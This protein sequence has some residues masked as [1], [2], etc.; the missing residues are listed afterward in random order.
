MYRKR[1]ITIITVCFFLIM[2]CSICKASAQ[3][4]LPATDQGALDMELSVLD[5]KRA[6]VMTGTPQDQIVN[7]SVNNAV[8]EYYNNYTD[9]CIALKQGKIDC[10]VNNTIQF[11][12]IG[13]EYPEFSYVNR[14]MTS[15]D[16]GAVFPLTNHGS[17][18][19]NEFDSYLAEIEKDGTLD[20]LK[21][22][23]L[24]PNDWEPCEIPSKG[25]KGTLKLGTSTSMKPFS[26]IVNEK[27]SGFD[28]AVVSEFCRRQG[29]GLQIEDCDLAGVL[30]GI[31]TG[32]YDIGAGQIAWTQER[33][34]SVLY[35]DL[36]VSQ[37]IVAFVR[38]ADFQQSSDINTENT[39]LLAK[40]K[41]SYRKT[42]VDENR[43]KVILKGLLTT[44]IISIAGFILAN[45][46]GGIFCAM[47][48]SPYR[49]W[50]VI[51]DI[52][53]RIMQGT[54]MIVI[55]MILYYVVFG[56]SDYSGIV[57][58]ILGFGLADGAYLSQIFRQSIS[59]VDRGQ[60][61]AALTLGMTKYQAFTGI[62]LPQ[63]IRTMLPA[64][65]SQFISLMKST[66]IVGYIA[67]IDLTKAGDII[68]SSTY[69]AFFPLLTSAAIYFVISSILLSLMK[70]IQA[71][72]A[73]KR[74]KA[75]GTND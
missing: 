66:S 41:K 17:E 64:Y 55:L 68:R 11:Q 44:L 59:G 47:N 6:G 19:K 53:S 71:A 24:N 45:L 32:K 23:W 9:L 58:A 1:F 48:L 20:Q 39:G 27:I 5:G 51:A 30:S 12:F 21:E 49:V 33:S 46:L 3:E 35:S 40:I 29:Y 22:Y 63:A 57:I 52:Y 36:Y 69:E 67:V 54:P 38:T 50:H 28:I 56:H 7:N 62:V 31:S 15:F 43:W 75:G 34:E 70:K 26:F 37:K 14:V 42:F 61:E 16:N 72:L 18:L 10:F 65:F 74:R 25:E 13:K 60:M 4:I 2:A 73:P 8:I